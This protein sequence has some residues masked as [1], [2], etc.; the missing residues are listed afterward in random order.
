MSTPFKLLLIDRDPVFRMG[1]RAWLQQ[2]SDLEAIAET[3][4]GTEALAMLAKQS[5]QDDSQIDLAILDLGLHGAKDAARSDDVF[6]IT[7]CEL[8]KSQYPKL[9]ILLL[10][11]PQPS[12]IVTAALRAG[13]DGYC[14]KGTST[15]EL[16]NAI[17]TCASGGKYL[18]K[19]DR[20]DNISWLDRTPSASS[21]A[22][23]DEVVSA[24][25]VMRRNLRISGLSRID[26]ALSGVQAYLA[27]SASSESIW[28]AIERIVLEGRQRELLTSR[29]LVTHIFPVSPKIQAK[30]SMPRQAYSDLI[31]SQAESRQPSEKSA[32]QSA[33]QSPVNE[34][35]LVR[36]SI[37]ASRNIRI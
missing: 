13:V 21:S 28:H 10:T 15:D 37:F 31:Y 34:Q 9:S 12:T 20:L 3:G 18:D 6:G 32:G 24:M 25:E 2:F 27:D 30:S 4:T 17:R 5:A 16:V 36:A 8:I 11:S 14:L 26:R 33:G 22:S 23:Q 29:W 7:L 19:L 1:M 35:Q